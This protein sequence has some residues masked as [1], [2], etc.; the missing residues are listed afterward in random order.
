MSK[1]KTMKAIL[2]DGSA[3]PA[4]A[5][6]DRPIPTQ[7]E[8]LVRVLQAGICGTDLSILAGKHPRARAP[9]ILGHE[10]AAQVHEIGETAR[11]THPGLQV[12][13]LVTIEP[14]ISCGHCVA[15]RSGVPH[16]CGS[17]RLYGID[18]PGGMAEFMA[19]RADRVVPTPHGMSPK[20]VVLAEP[21][22]VAVHS[23]RLA[24][25]R[26]GDSVCVIGGGPIGLLIALVARRSTS[27][28][29]L[30]SEPE[31]S[32]MRV[33]EK[34]GFEV[35][36]PGSSSLEE[37]VEKRTQ[38]RGI[39]VVF[40]AAG[41]Q[42]AVSSATKIA[43]PR[44]IVVQVSIPKEPR[45]VSLV[46]LTFKELVLKGVRVYEPFDFEHALELLL[47]DAE[48]F[49]PLLSRSFALDE[50]AEAFDAARSGDKGLRIIFDI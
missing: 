17:L 19:V 5:V 32:R 42:G 30:I 31:P 41:S 11:S 23:V 7:N 18:L 29:V 35:V 45:A 21:L 38:G 27:K 43:R 15:C 26:Y 34:L 1:Q 25:L 2:F 49:A 9:L 10:V 47:S 39:D 24:G 28:P 6:L 33:A 4:V 48:L 22:A 16:V 3:Q 12:G 40:E 50:A 8:V 20:M 44:G 46:D 13:D 37:I 36:D 14:I